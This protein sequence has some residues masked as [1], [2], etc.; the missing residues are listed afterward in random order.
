MTR[1]GDRL[2]PISKKQLAEDVFYLPSHGTLNHDVAYV[3]S[4]SA[5]ILAG[6]IVAS[7]DVAH[8]PSRHGSGDSTLTFLNA[9]Q[10]GR[11]VCLHAPRWVA[12]R[13]LSSSWAVV[14]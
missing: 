14:P 2:V 5:L 6:S 10:S 4:A 3:K 1:V 13:R 11:F 9:C 8:W 7:D 12:F